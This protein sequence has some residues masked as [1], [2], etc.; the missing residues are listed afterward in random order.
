MDCSFNP[1]EP[2]KQL[3]RSV[4]IILKL[5]LWQRWCWCKRANQCGGKSA[6][7]RTGVWMVAP[8]CG[9]HNDEHGDQIWSWQCREI[10]QQEEEYDCNSIMIVC[11]RPVLTRWVNVN[12]SSFFQRQRNQRKGSKKKKLKTKKKTKKKQ[13]RTN[14]NNKNKNN[15]LKSRRASHAGLCVMVTWSLAGSANSDRHQI[16][17]FA[18]TRGNQ[19][20]VCNKQLYLPKIYYRSSNDT[21]A[22]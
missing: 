6:F 2:W 20:D 15:T 19:I 11:A 3:W 10:H 1:E 8:D 22:S 12:G 14:K 21:Q 7:G 4:T 5:I 18:L 17:G 9:G 16:Q 13:K